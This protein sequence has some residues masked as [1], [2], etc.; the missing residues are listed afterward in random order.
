M[1]ILEML[2]GLFRVI[3]E[4]AV[5]DIAEPPVDQSSMAEFVRLLQEDKSADDVS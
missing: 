1:S 4:S 5:P 3:P 2:M